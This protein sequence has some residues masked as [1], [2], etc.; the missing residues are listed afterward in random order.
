MVQ[1]RPEQPSA[2]DDSFASPSAFGPTCPFCHAE[3]SGE[4]LRIL[5]LDY[6]DYESVGFQFYGATIAIVCH[7]CHREM[8]RKDGVQR[9]Y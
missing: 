2:V 6:D 4:N 8:Y 7:A 1:N 3:R 5:D 9:Y